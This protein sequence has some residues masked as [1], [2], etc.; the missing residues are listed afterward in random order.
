MPADE[1]DDNDIILEIYAGVGGQEAMLF[2]GD[3]L[4]MYL[5]YAA[6]RGW[7]V[8]VIDSCESDTGQYKIE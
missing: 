2:A 4:S 8:E 1:V 3:V 7:H 6:Y 5:N